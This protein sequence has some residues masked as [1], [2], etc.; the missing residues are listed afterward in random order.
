VNGQGKLPSK[1][2]LL[3]FDDGYT[4]NFTYALPLLKQYNMKGTVF[5]VAGGVGNFCSWLEKHDCNRLM[6]WEQ[7]NT[8]LKAGMEVG[9][10][11]VN[12]PMLSRLSE[13]EILYELKTSKEVL[14]M[15]LKTK[16]DYLCYPYGD[17]DD[18]VKTLAKEAGYKGALAIFD[19]VSLSRED[20]YAIPRIGISSRQ[21]LWEFKLK[22]SR[23]HRYFIGMRIVERKIK[24]FL[25]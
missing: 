18:R 17:F 1:P 15:K 22:V 24:K 21:P 25:R 11:T 8:W 19:Q 12:H 14:E 6:T 7:L 16:V 10:H 3:T 20:L 2:V 9:A 5:V 4:D 23:L 13:D